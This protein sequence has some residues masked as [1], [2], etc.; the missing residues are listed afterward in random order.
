[1]TRSRVYRAGRLEAEDFP[2][3]ELTR[4]LADPDA[5]VWLDFTE[6]T[7]QDLAEVAQAL[8]LH[9]IAVK[10]AV[11]KHQRPKLNHYNNHGLLIAYE[12]SINAKTGALHAQELAVFL[13]KQALVTVGKSSNM[14]MDAVTERWDE[15]ADQTAAGVGYLLYT[16]LDAVVNSHIDSLGVLDDLVEQLEDA[17]FSESPTSMS[18]QKRSLRTHKSL[19]GL[20][21]KVSPMHDILNSLLRRENPLYTAD[22][23]P[24]YQ[25]VLDHVLYANEQVESLRDLITT[26]H[27]TQVNLQGNRMNLIMKKVTSWAAI[28]AVPTL[29]TGVYGQNVPVPGTDHVWGFWLSTVAI[30]LASIGL[31]TSFKRK[32]WL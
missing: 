4:Y 30:V 17:V 31:Y 13:T 6:P 23:M 8:G 19:N 27:D 32:D 3:S 2:P 5:V 20:R 18:L 28:I 16:V 11:Q 10:D 12:T 7:E 29:I 21:R 24:Y 1:M 22:M 25:D 15:E 26:I 9:A 14:S